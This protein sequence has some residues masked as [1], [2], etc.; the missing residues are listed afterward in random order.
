LGVTLGGLTVVR[1]TGRGATLGVFGVVSATGATLGG[2]TVTM[3]LAFG[4]TLDGFCIV[5]AIGTG[6]AFGDLFVTSATSADKAA[7]AGAPAMGRYGATEGGEALDDLDV[8]AA[9]GAMLAGAG[10][11][12]H[13]PSSSVSS[14][15]PPALCPLPELGAA[16]F[17]M[18]MEYP[19]GAPRWQL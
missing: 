8:A 1:A 7:G 15:S 19:Q 18:P 3:G 16:P 12:S 2:F 11:S 13:P 4:A 10:S 9:G 6:V 14:S 5:S 17:A